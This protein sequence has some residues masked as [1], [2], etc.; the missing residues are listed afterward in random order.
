MFMGEGDQ[1]YHFGLVNLKLSIDFQMETSTKES[2]VQ[3][4]KLGLEI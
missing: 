4:R 2:E 3:R 1:E